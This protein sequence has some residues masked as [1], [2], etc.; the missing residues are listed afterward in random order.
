MKFIPR[1]E[2]SNDVEPLTLD[3]FIRICN[4]VGVIDSEARFLQVLP[5][6]RRLSMN[7]RML[8]DHLDALLERGD[9]EV[10]QSI[11]LGGGEHFYIRAMIWPAMPADEM[12]A[13]TL[14]RYAY[15]VPHDHN[16]SFMTIGYLGSGYRTRFFRSDRGLREVE[17]SDRLSLSGDEEFNLR[18]GDVAIVDEYDD[19]H[20][21]YPP[22]SMSVS[23]NVVPRSKFRFKQAFISTEGVVVLPLAF[24]SHYGQFMELADL[25]ASSRLRTAVKTYYAA[26]RG[27]RTV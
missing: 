22:E 12:D 4:R 18:E 8:V 17:V 20:I 2:P 25:L 14:Y 3:A 11:L 1:S 23:L 5:A 6:L 16:F 21:Q 19:V 13:A 10:P 24:S 9:Q 15:C 26:P 7:K 27:R